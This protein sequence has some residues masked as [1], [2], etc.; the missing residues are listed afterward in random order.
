MN[1]VVGLGCLV[2]EQHVLALPARATE[3][4]IGRGR[5]ARD[6]RLLGQLGGL[7]GVTDLGAVVGGEAV[8]ADE[9]GAALD[10]LATEVR[11]VAAG[12]ELLDHVEVELGALGVTE[13]A[14]VDARTVTPLKVPPRM[15]RYAVL[16][17]T[18]EF[19]WTPPLSDRLGSASYL[20]LV[21][22]SGWPYAV[23]VLRLRIA[24]IG[25]SSPMVQESL[26]PASEPVPVV[27]DLAHD[28]GERLVD[29]AGLEVVEE[30]GVL[31]DHA[32]RHLVADDVV[33]AGVA[34][35]VEHLLTVPE[36]VVVR[37]LRAEVRHLAVA[38]RRAE[39][40]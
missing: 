25:R 29:G 16:L 19:S 13:V 11:V 8:R 1:S 7:H 34:R 23:G 31:R 4:G 33:R 37:A 39:R 9:V 18:P 24:S 12:G 38:H 36:G 14:A 5:R 21:I 30:V 3:G 15:I 35:A 22:L 27:D 26:S 2:V 6:G 17:P 40:A 10:E 32:V 28:V 20:V